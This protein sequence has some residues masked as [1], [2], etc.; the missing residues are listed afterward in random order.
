MEQTRPLVDM[1]QQEIDAWYADNGFSNRYNGHELDGCPWDD[2]LER[3]NNVSFD[4]I[5]PDHPNLQVEPQ[6]FEEEPERDNSWDEM[7]R[8]SLCIILGQVPEKQLNAFYLVKKEKKTI[9]QAG[10]EMGISHQAVHHLVAKAEANILKYCDMLGGVDLKDLL[11]N[12]KRGG[13]P[14]M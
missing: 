4:E 9:R 5:E 12:N 6:I 11:F 8:A 7:L 14:K 10:E 1:T 3:M 13:L 2:A